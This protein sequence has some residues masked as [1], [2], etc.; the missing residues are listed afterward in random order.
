[1]ASKTYFREVSTGHNSSRSFRTSALSFLGHFIMFINYD[2]GVNNLTFNCGVS[3][4]QFVAGR[5]GR[6]VGSGVGVICKAA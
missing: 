4:V 2:P 5:R 3:T 6:T 1:M